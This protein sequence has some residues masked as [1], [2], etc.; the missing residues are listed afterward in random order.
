MRFG[1]T[2]PDPPRIAA[3]DGQRS[4]LK[5]TLHSPTAR[6]DLARSC[7]DRCRDLRP[8]RARSANSRRERPLRGPRRLIANNRN[9]ARPEL[10]PLLLDIA[11]P[12]GYFDPSPGRAA[13]CGAL[14][15]GP[16]GTVSALHHDTSNILLC[17]IFGR[18]RVRLYPPDEP[19]LLA[20]ARGVYSDL[21]PE[22]DAAGL[23]GRGL[24]VVLAPGEALFLPVGWWHHVRALDVSISLA[25]NHFLWPND[26]DWY[27]PGTLG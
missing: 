22:R 11:L 10:R 6:P 4:A 18:K 23:A 5:R 21:D 1:G 26:F 2:P 15:F 19:R 25:F 8:D 13:R 9:L 24:D 12:S 3:E 20:A 14:W 7:R 27:K 17:Q 16:A